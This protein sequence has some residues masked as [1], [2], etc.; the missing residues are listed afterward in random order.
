MK[1]RFK[2]FLLEN[3]NYDDFLSK[4]GYSY[5][6]IFKSVHNEFPDYEDAIFETDFYLRILKNLYEN[7][8]EIYRLVFLDNIKKLKKSDLGL[9]WTT[10]TGN[11]TRF[12]NTLRDNSDG[13]NGYLITANIEPEQVDVE[14]SLDAFKSLPYENEINLKYQPKNY[15]IKLFKY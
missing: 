8:G 1:I 6:D 14:S 4:Y 5:D 2:D 7:G 11:F 9:H 15:K 13:K 10:D 12:Y 3:N